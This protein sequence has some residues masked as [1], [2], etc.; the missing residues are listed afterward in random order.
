MPNA[1]TAFFYKMVSLDCLGK[2]KGFSTI[3]VSRTVPDCPG[4]SRTV[5]DCPGLSGT[6]PDTKMPNSLSF[7]RQICNLFGPPWN[8][9]P[10]RYRTVFAVVPKKEAFTIFFLCSQKKNPY[11]KSG[12]SH[13]VPM[14]QDNIKDIIDF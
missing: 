12:F 14:C 13:R 10:I 4:L 9:F 8:H 1:K 6:V 3:F 5:R 11:T 7:P 2:L